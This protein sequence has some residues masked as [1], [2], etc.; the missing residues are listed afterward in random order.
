MTANYQGI[1]LALVAT[2]AYNT[3]FVLEKRA[4]GT[5]PSIN[6]RRPRQLLGILFSAPSWLVGFVCMLFGLGCQLIVL[7]MLPI[8]VA[9]PLQ[10][11]GIPVLTL[12]A[13]LVLGERPRTRDWWRLG[14]VSGSILLLGLSIDGATRPGKTAADPIPVTVVVLLAV[15]AVAVLYV[16]S[17]PRR[18]GRHRVRAH[19]ISAGMATGLVYGLSGLG[20]KG[21]S[22]SFGHGLG[23]LLAS[24]YLYLTGLSSVAG[25]VM[26]QTALQRYRASVVI[27]TSNVVGS[28]YVLLCGTLLFHETLPPQP[29]LLGLRAAGLLV[30]VLALAIQPDAEPETGGPGYYLDPCPPR[31]KESHVTRRPFARHSRLSRR[32]RR[33]A[34]LRR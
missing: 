22:V 21:L 32:Q 3:G 34:V 23:G 8:T 28:A 1:G 19:G 10:A 11:G 5:L 12:M 7:G 31:W 9:Q 20:M 18:L 17:F 29:I 16:T 33:A 30:A 25:M 26:F 4:L 24:P 15:A 6:V 2:A 13:W 14:A 27:P